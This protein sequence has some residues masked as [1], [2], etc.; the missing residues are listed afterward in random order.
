VSE[1]NFHLETKLVNLGRP[2]HVAGAP[3]NVPIGLSSTFVAGENSHGYVREGTDLT[4]ALEAVIGSVEGGHSTVFSSG[5][6]TINA[7]VDLLPA[8]AI[9]VA[10]NHAYPGNSVR[11]RE[12]A[13][14]N[15]I[16]LREVQIDD[17]E[18]IRAAING[19]SLLW[20]ESPTNPL[21]EIVD[22]KAAI[23]LGHSQ[24][25]L[26]AV[27]NTFMS[28]VRQHPL[29]LGADISMHSATKSIAGH[30][31]SLIG[32]LTVKDAELAQQ[33]RGRR[34]LQGTLPGALETYLALRGIRTLNL[35]YD[36]AEQNAIALAKRLESHPAIEYVLYP[37]LESHKHHTRHLNQASGGGHVVCFVLKGNVDQAEEFCN[38]VRIWAHATSLGGVESTIERRRRWPAEPI[39]TPETL[40]RASVGIENVEDLWA[41]L[42]SALKSVY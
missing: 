17:T 11:L 31:D 32:V 33:L 15:R 34:V 26:V 2:E 38:T 16:Q 28:P 27:D 35:R 23:D 10:P 5:I 8:N 19:A 42:D 6:A 20:L 30:S 25:A 4:E 9:V 22:L 12:L 41:D 37:G 18:E 3:M 29:E 7:V 24:N 36:R 13:A 39:A 40:I 14:V 21:M 1:Q